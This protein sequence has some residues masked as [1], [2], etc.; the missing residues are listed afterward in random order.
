MT[1]ANGRKPKNIK[2]HNLRYILSIVKKYGVCTAGEISKESNLSMTT[3]VKTLDS[4][5][6]AGIVKSIGKGNSTS[7][8]GK[9]PELF[10]FNESFQYVLCVYFA[11]KYAM[12]TLNDLSNNKIE[13]KKVCYTDASDVDSC[14]KEVYEKLRLMMDENGLTEEDICGISLGID[15]IVD[16]E[17][18]HV[19]YPIHNQQ[20]KTGGYIAECFKEYFPRTENIQIENS[21]RLGS[22]NYLNTYP[23]LESERVVVLNSSES[24]T[25]GAL[26]QN[27]AVQ[28]GS[29]CL[30]GEFAH[31]MIPNAKGSVEC[32]CGRR[33]CFEKLIALERFEEYILEMIDSGK[34]AELYRRVRGHELAAPELIGL[35]DAGSVAG[36]KAMDLI[37]EYYLSVIYNLMITSD[38]KYYVIGG[39]YVRN[40][41][42][43][44][45]ELSRRFDENKFWGIQFKARILYD[46]DDSGWEFK[47]MARPVIDRFLNTLKLDEQADC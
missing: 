34:E 30:I 19:V 32:E 27:N 36:R 12:C 3:I 21:G 18:N 40:S 38:P 10:A 42:Y 6:R 16:S 43:F 23:E 1:K 9:R 46:M 11:G 20:W 31:M 37:I 33:N 5:K 25:A 8:G 39:I 47:N 35:A 45:R 44:R 13:A 29:N 41:E 2:Y 17:K 15:G 28:H 24:L 22:W 14:M 4:L 7:E 26:H